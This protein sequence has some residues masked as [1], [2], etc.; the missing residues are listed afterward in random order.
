M[1]LTG[2]KNRGCDR[3]GPWRRTPEGGGDTADRARVWSPVKAAFLTALVGT[4]GSAVREI[5]LLSH[6]RYI[7]CRIVFTY[8][9]F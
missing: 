9:K 6:S 4:A 8:E 5:H 3:A 7:S 1:D 2:D